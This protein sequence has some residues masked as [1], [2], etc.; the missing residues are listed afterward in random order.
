MLFAESC[1]RFMFGRERE[2]LFRRP[3]LLAIEQQTK[4]Y[5][6][7]NISGID[8]VTGPLCQVPTAYAAIQS[9]GG[10][11]NHGIR[12]ITLPYL[13]YSTGGIARVQAAATL[14]VVTS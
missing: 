14:L 3:G 10:G 12:W 6:F 5:S 2:K 7:F 4:K 9:T 8:L 11:E 1:H 13:S